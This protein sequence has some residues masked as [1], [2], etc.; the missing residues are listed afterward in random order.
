MSEFRFQSVAVLGATGSVGKTL[1]EELLKRKVRVRAVSRSAENL[2][3]AFGAQPVDRVTAELG[4][5]ADAARALDGRDAAIFCVGAPMSEQERLVPAARGV[6]EAISKHKIPVLVVSCAWTYWPIPEG[7]VKEDATRHP[8]A[9]PAQGRRTAED[10]L[11]EAGAGVAV[12]PEIY[13]PGVAHSLLNEALRGLVEKGVAHWPANTEV[14]R[15]FLYLADAGRVLAELAAAP[16]A[17]GHRWHVT[18][19]A[20]ATPQEMVQYAAKFMEVA[21]KVRGPG[22]FSSA[23]ALVSKDAKAFKELA[24]VYDASLVLDGSKLRR[25]MGKYFVTP[26]EQGVE[27]T[28]RWLRGRQ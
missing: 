13:G 25:V 27:E 9:K 21:A 16:G 28:V 6:A 1:V 8:L 7:P 26:H 19:P 10:I 11:A 20:P 2:K 12:L 3:R 18:G 15:D 23:A 4:S 24:G 14:K 22:M 5:A 17:Y